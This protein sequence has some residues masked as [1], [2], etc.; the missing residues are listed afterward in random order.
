MSCVR[1]VLA[2]PIQ[3]VRR[4]KRTRHVAESRRVSESRSRNVY[5]GEQV[6][7]E[8]PFVAIMWENHMILLTDVRQQDEPGGGDDVDRHQKLLLEIVTINNDVL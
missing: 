2:N 7:G 1:Y 5:G 8:G 6:G 4:K 3:Y